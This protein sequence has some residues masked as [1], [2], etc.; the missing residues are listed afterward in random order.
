M[1]A[2]EV[3]GRRDDQFVVLIILLILST[4]L[5]VGEAN[6]EERLSFNIP[7]QRADLA[8]TMFAEQADLTL[9]FPFDK[10]RRET[11]NQLIGEYSLEEAVQILLAGTSLNATF[12]QRLVISISTDSETVS[13]EGK[14]IQK[15]DTGLFALLASILTASAAQAQETEN[16]DAPVQLEEIIVTA[17]KREQNIQDVPISVSVLSG[18]YLDSAR[19]QG[20]A[21][22]LNQVAGVNLFTNGQSGANKASVRGVTAGTALFG[23]SGAVGYY[24]DE[25]PFGLAKSAILPD[26]NAYDLE[27]VEVLRGPQGTLYGASALNGVIRILT[28]DARLD[29]FEFKGR[30]S[31]S[32]TRGADEN[33]DA[34]IAVNIPL[35]AGKVAARAVVGYKDMSGWIDRV[36]SDGSMTRDG[37]NDAQLANARFKIK[38]LPTEK[39][40]VNVSAWF[41]RA[42]NGAASIASDDGIQNSV[43]D[44]PIEIDY[45]IF[46]LKIDY[47]FANMSLLSSTSY[48]DYR[49]TRVQDIAAIDTLFQSID[50]EVFSQEFRLNSA[51]DGSWQWSAGAF[52]RIAKDPLLQ[53]LPVFLAA[54]ISWTDKSESIALFGEFTRTF[55]N[56]GADF[57][58]GL[59]FF[60][61]EVTIS[62]TIRN[63]GV[64]GEPLVTSRSTF[65]TVSPR[66]VLTWHPS[67]AVVV[68]GSYAQGFRSGFD[69]NPL[70]L[71]VAPQFPAVREDTLN[72]FEIG[73]KGTVLNGR[74]IF[75]SA[76]YYIDWSD[77]QQ[78]VGVPINAEGQSVNLFAPI[79]GKS[80]SGVGLDFGVSFVPIEGLRLGST[81]GWNDL[82]MDEEVL[83]SGVILFNKGD[84]LVDSP[85]YTAGLTGTYD[86]ELGS[87]GYIGQLA[88]SAHYHSKLD[89]RTISGG[90]LAIREGDDILV[91]R[92]GVSVYSPKSW[93]TTVYVDNVGNEDGAVTRGTNPFSSPRIRPLTVGVQFEYHA[94]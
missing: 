18:E 91:T 43:V 51:L 60:E 40:T 50:S 83:S 13:G 69:Q 86:F 11:A 16:P 85:E 79:N 9:I 63:T 35:V 75:D 41:S 12:S 29:E 21:E 24:I 15:K 26:A 53:V 42:K 90:A 32:T 20:V 25:V 70:V 19:F 94:N 8:L 14:M 71:T 81:F 5:M 92:F 30:T 54:P 48:M 56:G 7:Q 23:G 38:A 2:S 68:Y 27:R 45:D 78:T 31:A 28:K 22:S 36:P 73:A 3:R 93:T 49:S 66:A 58:V 44:E 17:Q 74:L 10:A 64:P 6:G 67:D 39:M 77:V 88:A 76:V 82:S 62:E 87:S 59:R 65:D 72:N 47:D 46:G 61:D 52:Y 4:I 57:T 80:A 34:D 33:Y 37:A 1:C 89:T 55:L 84:R